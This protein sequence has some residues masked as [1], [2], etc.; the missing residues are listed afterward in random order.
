MFANISFACRVRVHKNAGIDDLEEWPGVKV[1][2]SFA[3]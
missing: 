2:D 3:S 1:G